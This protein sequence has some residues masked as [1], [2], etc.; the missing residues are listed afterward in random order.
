M[1]HTGQLVLRPFDSPTTGI[2]VEDLEFNEVQRTFSIVVRY[3]KLDDEISA[4][5]SDKDILIY[6]YEDFMSSFE[7]CSNWDE[8][9]LMSEAV[10]KPMKDYEME[11]IDE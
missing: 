4:V 1:K 11:V 6:Q 7:L 5:H 8:I 3:F 10:W 9:N 2:L